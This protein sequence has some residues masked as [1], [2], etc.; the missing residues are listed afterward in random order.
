[1]NQ[2]TNFDGWISNRPC[3]TGGG[4]TFVRFAGCM[5]AAGALLTNLGTG[6]EISL[7]TYHQISQRIN[8][9]A[10]QVEGQPQEHIRTP[11]QDLIH[12][13]EVLKPP[14]S[15]LAQ[16][17]GVTRQSVYNWLNGESV[18]DENAARIND[19]ARAAD[20]MA[21]AGIT[22]DST[23][24]KRKNTNDQTLLQ[25]VRAGGSAVNAAHWLVNIHKREAVQRERMRAKFSARTKT[26]ASADFDL[27]TS[28]DYSRG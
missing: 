18:S 24:L 23:L 5:T 12:I 11:N 10:P 16:A 19:L 4:V 22:T 15:E 17:F 7:E 26:P 6:G 25:V 3:A 28:N 27:P 21:H 2:L 1:M 9:V 13:R 8:L 20:L 14:I